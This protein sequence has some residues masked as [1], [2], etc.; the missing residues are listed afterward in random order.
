MGDDR[1]GADL[2]IE[3]VYQ[4]PDSH[5]KKNGTLRK[6]IPVHKRGI[7][8]LDKLLRSTND[9]LT[10]AGVFKDDSH[11][12]NVEMSKR[13]AARTELHGIRIEVRRTPDGLAGLL[14]QG[15]MQ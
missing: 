9:A 10:M 8:D 15:E 13:Y 1:G 5:W 4:R 6:G 2:K 12:V 7:P 14:A 3:F 11:V